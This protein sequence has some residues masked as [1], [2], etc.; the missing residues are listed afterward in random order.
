MEVSVHNTDSTNPENTVSVNNIL[1]GDVW[2]ASG[3]SNME[4]TVNKTFSYEYDVENAIYDEIRYFAQK[5]LG[6]ME[7]L[8]D[9]YYGSWSVAT[10]S[11]ISSYSAVA[12]HFAREL[13][14]QNNKEIPIA[15]VAAR[16]SG[17]RIQA[18]MSEEL[19]NS[20]PDFMNVNNLRTSDPYYKPASSAAFEQR[21]GASFNAAVNPILATNIKGVIWYQGEENSFQPEFYEKALPALMSSWRE[22]FNA[23]DMPFYIVGIPSHQPSSTNAKWSEM[24]EVQLRVALSDKSSGVTVNM[25]SGDKYDIH[26]KT[27]MPVGKRLAYLAAAK[28]YNKNIEYSGP[29]YSHVTVDNDMVTVHFTHADKLKTQ[30]LNPHYRPGTDTPEFIDIDNANVNGFELSSDGVN[31]TPANAVISENKVIVSGVDNPVALRYG[32][33]AFPEPVL[34]LYNSADLPAMPFRI[35]SFSDT[36]TTPVLNISDGAATL[37]GTITNGSVLSLN[38][39]VIL[40]SYTYD[41]KLT[42]IKTTPITALINTNNNYTSYINCPQDGTVKA[43]VWDEMIPLTDAVLK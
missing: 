27:K 30:I 21:A 17:T 43:F 37:T 34:N 3:Q 13:Y 1:I 20:D 33:S 42:E 9:S 39:T 24:R 32:W 12:Y 19:L 15:I 5:T 25:D 38:A 23:P 18:W 2:V 36:Q 41:G 35:T 8:E 31:F 26:P 16:M 14:E 11:A 7:P 4:F 10:G 40:A 29:L 6:S 28:T 22:E